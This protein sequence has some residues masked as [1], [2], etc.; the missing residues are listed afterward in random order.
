MKSVLFYIPLKSGTLQQYLA[1]A[2]Q[3]TERPVEY[4][5]MLKR[6][7]IHSAK[8]WHGAINDKNYVFVCHEV[9]PSFKEK[10]GSWDSS[11]HPFDVWFRESIMAVYDIESAAT[12]EEPQQVLD[13]KA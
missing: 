8:V 3:T 12:V 11:T 4:G 6:Y 2:K 13:F 7:D 10:M 9:G 1:F 5:E